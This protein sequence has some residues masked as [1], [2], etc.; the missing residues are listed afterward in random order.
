M[1]QPWHVITR[2]YY[3]NGGHPLL[4]H[5]CRVIYAL[6]WLGET[7][8]S[9]SFSPSRVLLLCVAMV[10]SSFMLIEGGCIKPTSKHA[11]L[12]S[13]QKQALRADGISH[14]KGVVGWEQAVL[15]CRRSGSPCSSLPAKANHTLL[16]PA[17]ASHHLSLPPAPCSIIPSPLPAPVPYPDYSGT[18]GLQHSGGEGH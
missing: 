13:E 18:V 6:A 3:G 12:G 4:F 11:G 16:P 10:R 15:Q 8:P 5:C 14:V 7:H 2:G 17:Q 9:A 1:P